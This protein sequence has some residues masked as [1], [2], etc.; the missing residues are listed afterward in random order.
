MWEHVWDTQVLEACGQTGSRL[1]LGA[2][3]ASTRYTYTR[4]MPYT[5]LIYD[6]RDEAILEH[7]QEEGQAI[8]WAT[9]APILPTILVNGCNGIATGY[10]KFIFLGLGTANFTP[11]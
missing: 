5:P 2:D 11:L 3:A 6:E 10:R 7:R 8:E 9:Y 1:H 4:I